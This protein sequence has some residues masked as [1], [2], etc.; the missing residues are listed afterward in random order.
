MKPLDLQPDQRCCVASEVTTLRDILKFRPVYLRGCSF[1][2]DLW[3]QADARDRQRDARRAK[4]GGAGDLEVE[5][6]ATGM[7][8][9]NDGEV[10]A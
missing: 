5:E 10:R 8:P 9:T 4:A 1:H 6:I 2:S 3:R 7:F